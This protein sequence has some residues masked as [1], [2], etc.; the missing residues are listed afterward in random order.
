MG[1]RMTSYRLPLALSSLVAVADSLRTT[2][3]A[4]IRVA[5]ELTPEAVWDAIGAANDG[6]VVRLPPG[7]AVWKRG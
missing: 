2:V 5:A 1:I 7:T 4:E 3:R 6:D